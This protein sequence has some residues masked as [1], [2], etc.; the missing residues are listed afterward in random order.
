MVVTGIICLLQDSFGNGRH[1]WDV[2]GDNFTQYLK[3]SQFVNKI[4]STHLTSFI[5]VDLCQR[6]HI[7]RNR[8]LHQA[9]NSLPLLS[10][11]QTKARHQD[12]TPG[13]HIRKFHILH[14]RCLS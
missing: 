2:K 4:P 1:L 6:T 5:I 13:S 14:D 3:V 7:H 9:L 10:G 8:V 12:C 11:L